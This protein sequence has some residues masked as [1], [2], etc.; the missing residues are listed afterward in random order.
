MHLFFFAYASAHSLPFPPF[1]P[2]F[3]TIHHFSIP[4]VN[5]Q[6]FNLNLATYLTRRDRI[7]SVAPFP[8]TPTRNRVRQLQCL[9]RLEINPF[10]C[11]AWRYPLFSERCDRARSILLTVRFFL[12]QLYL[13][14]FCISCLFLTCYFKPL[15]AFAGV[16]LNVL[17][18]FHL[19]W[20]GMW[21]EWLLICLFGGE[22]S[23]PP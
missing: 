4:H 15:F 3:T 2:L 22:R 18:G 5:P 17:R 23:P 16:W 11:C 1:L 8:F 7:S 14:F 9:R 10:R 12:F 13:C 20:C 19:H 21:M 6:G